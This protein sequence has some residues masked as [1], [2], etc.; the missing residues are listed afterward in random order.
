MTRRLASILCLALALVL[1]GVSL[2]VARADNEGWVPV[3]AEP[4][5]GS[6]P[7]GR[8][9]VFVRPDSEGR[10]GGSPPPEGLA[11]ALARPLPDGFSDG[12]DV[13]EGFVE[14]LAQVPGPEFWHFGI[15]PN[16]LLAV[17][18]WPPPDGFSDGGDG[19]G[20]WEPVLFET[21]DQHGPGP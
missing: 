9:V 18:A 8:I 6:V 14:V 7:D 21:A 2:G 1:L 4:F 3:L 13:P 19:M 11:W 16:G 17:L 5:E 10:H 15:V 12:G 20:R